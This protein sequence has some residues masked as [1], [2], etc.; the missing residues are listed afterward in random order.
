LRASDPP[1]LA[2]E[3]GFSRVQNVET[4]T[5]NAVDSMFEELVVLA[6]I[7]VLHPFTVV[8]TYDN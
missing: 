3:G 7:E 4:D 1:P 6:L 8:K 2:S 5:D